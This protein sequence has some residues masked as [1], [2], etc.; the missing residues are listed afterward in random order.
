[1]PLTVSRPVQLGLNAA[2]SSIPADFPLY[3]QVLDI[4]AA[5][6]TLPERLADL[7][8]ADGSV[9]TAASF[10]LARGNGE[11]SPLELMKWFDTN[12]HYL[13][14][15]IG[16]GMRFAAVAHQLAHTVWRHKQNGATLRPVL[17]GPVT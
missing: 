6:G 4:T 5:L 17:V 14:A 10:V 1:M 16:P 7:A 9:G 12:Y 3:A 13:V 11:R 2:D 15:E 8:E